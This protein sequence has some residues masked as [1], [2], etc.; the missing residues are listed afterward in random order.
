MRNQERR[1]EA[2]EE[3]KYQGGGVKPSRRQENQNDAEDET[4]QDLQ[5]ELPPRGQAQVLAAPDFLVIVPET[6]G[7]KGQG[8]AQREPNED[9]A[10]V[11]PKHRRNNDTENDEHAAHG[12]RAR[13]GLVS[14]RPVF[15]DV[16]TNL[17]FLELP[18]QPRP[19]DERKE[20]GRQTGVSRA[21]GDVPK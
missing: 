5:Q 19:Q 14:L 4:D 1:A 6:D 3:R 16:L 8:H 11:R 9:V 17:E 18:H 10:E 12:G 2:L 20:Q 13:L 15:A 7:G 21:K